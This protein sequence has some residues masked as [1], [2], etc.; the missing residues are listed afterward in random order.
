MSIEGILK[1]KGKGVVTTGTETSVR[2]AAEMMRENNIAA[3]LVVDGAAIRGIVTER[4][5]VRAFVHYGANLL[6][7]PVKEIMTEKLITGSPGDSVKHVMSVMT[8]YRIRHFPVLREGRLEGL[9]SIGDVVRHRVD[10][11]ELEANVLRDAYIA[12]K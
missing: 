7:K 11:L 2:Q 3:L 8:R 9:I 12:A 5:I 4:D 6:V 10:D 1:R